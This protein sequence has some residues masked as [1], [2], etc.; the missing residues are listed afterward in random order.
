MTLISVRAEAHRQGELRTKA[1]EAQR[2]A[3]EKFKAFDLDNSGEIDCKL[4]HNV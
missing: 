3:A 1:L 4:L 2:I